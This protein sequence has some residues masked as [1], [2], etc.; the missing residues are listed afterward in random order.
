MN[1][2]LPASATGAATHYQAS[3]SPEQKTHPDSTIGFGGEIKQ[4]FDPDHMQG[5]EQTQAGTYEGSAD[6][7]QKFKQEGDNGDLLEDTTCPEGATAHGSVFIAYEP[8]QN[9]SPHDSTSEEDMSEEEGDVGKEEMEGGVYREHDHGF[10]SDQWGNGFLKRIFARSSDDPSLWEAFCADTELTSKSNG[11]S[12]SNK[13]VGSDTRQPSTINGILELGTVRFRTSPGSHARRGLVLESFEGSAHLELTTER[14]L[15]VIGTPVT[16]FDPKQVFQAITKLGEA[17]HHIQ[18]RETCCSSAEGDHTAGN[19]KRP[20]GTVPDRRA[21]LSDVLKW[22][23]GT[24]TGIV[25]GD[26]KI[27]LRLVLQAT[28]HQVLS[29]PGISPSNTVGRRPVD[30]LR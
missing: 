8:E 4:E 21:T 14:D 24:H 20:S 9:F 27:D 3:T 18:T 19:R 29:L 7:A 6:N 16:L 5:V 22:D 17:S 26:K 1:S 25:Y 23:L 10:H 28:S 11:N 13:P 12:H 30:E 15:E 2:E